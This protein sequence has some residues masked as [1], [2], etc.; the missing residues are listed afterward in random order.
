MSKNTKKLIGFVV[1]VVI[2]LAGMSVYNYKKNAELEKKKQVEVSKLQ[3][4]NVDIK[5]D[6][7]AEYEVLAGDYGGFRG[8][9]S[10][11]TSYKLKSATSLD[12][13][14]KKDSN[15]KDYKSD[16]I[17]VDRKSVL[18]SEE[19]EKILI[20]L[21]KSHSIDKIIK[22]SMD[23]ENFISKGSNYAYEKMLQKD[24]RFGLIK[25]DPKTNELVLYFSRI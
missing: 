25:Y 19:A 14:F 13:I 15:L 8:D 17:R 5:S 11:L 23:K 18:S 9:G 16:K 6:D 2:V 22:D 21:E 10:S 12:K 20:D 7:I 1:A 4:L 3:E 24:Y